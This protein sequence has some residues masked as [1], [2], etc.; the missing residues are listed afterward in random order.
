MLEIFRTGSCE[1]LLPGELR[2]CLSPHVRSESTPPVNSCYHPSVEYHHHSPVRFI[3][4]NV[5]KPPRA[6][7]F[8]S[9]RD[10]GDRDK[11]DDLVLDKARY[12]LVFRSLPSRSLRQLPRLCKGVWNNSRF[13]RPFRTPLDLRIRGSVPTAAAAHVSVTLPYK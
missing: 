2:S 8:R 10:K 6:D 5:V 12:F 1:A 7:D 13:F 11:V 9:R 3:G 4:C